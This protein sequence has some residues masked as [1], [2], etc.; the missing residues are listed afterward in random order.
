MPDI[1]PITYTDT[2][3][4]IRINGEAHKLPRNCTLADLVNQGDFNGKKIAAAINGE[5][6]PRSQYQQVYLCMHDNIDIVK[7]VGGG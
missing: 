6:V 3:I 2:T 4:S 1:T 7:P 5:F